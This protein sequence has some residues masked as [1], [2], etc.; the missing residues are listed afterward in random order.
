MMGGEEVWLDLWRVQLITCDGHSVWSP[1][2]T[3][4]R[5]SMVP[6]S[7]ET[8]QA[9]QL[10]EKNKHG[11]TRKKWYKEAWVAEDIYVV[12]CILWQSCERYL[13]HVP[14]ILLAEG[15]GQLGTP[16][17]SHTLCHS[18]SYF[19]T[20]IQLS[21]Q[22]YHRLGLFLAQASDTFQSFK[23]NDWYF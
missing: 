17:S 13:A 4:I 3:L 6:R 16:P 20:L 2:L 8:T 15:E 12:M 23:I 10:D 11:E 9:F 7:W 22:N 1:I 21:C 19:Q 5:W 18:V 14:V